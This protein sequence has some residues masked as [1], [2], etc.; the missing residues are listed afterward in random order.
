MIENLEKTEA[1]T[2]NIMEELR[3]I[4]DKISLDIQDMSF[5]ELQEYLEKR[6][7]LFDSSVW[8]K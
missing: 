5:E 7:K 6:E 1:S 2:K 8:E 3:E 4:R